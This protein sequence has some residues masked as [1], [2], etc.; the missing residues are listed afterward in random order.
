MAIQISFII[1]TPA[2]SS[3]SWWCS[4]TATALVR[5]LA[6]ANSG[7]TERMALSM[8]SR[9]RSPKLLAKHTA[10][11]SSFIPYRCK[12]NQ[13]LGFLRK[14]HRYLP[15][16]RVEHHIQALTT[17]PTAAFRERSRW[18]PR[19]FHQ[20]DHAAETAH[21]AF[22]RV[23]VYHLHL[24]SVGS[25]SST[26]SKA[27]PARRVNTYAPR[28][29]SGTFSPKASDL[30]WIHTFHRLYSFGS[31]LSPVKTRVPPA[32]AMDEFMANRARNPI[33]PETGAP[34]YQLQN[35]GRILPPDSRARTLFIL[36]RKRSL[37]DG[38]GVWDSPDMPTGVHGH[39]IDIYICIYIYT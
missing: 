18:E 20:T 22:W 2:P 9:L 16:A 11:C 13:P 27:F 33:L 31:S 21:P 39:A 7:Y 3:S 8:L 19:T 23:P 26:H 25:T 36:S 17:S 30:F 34:R 28:A 6:H 32:S 38:S 1:I 12:I 29:D 24:Y 10:F 5:Q 15:T 37:N 14:R 35:R 4:T